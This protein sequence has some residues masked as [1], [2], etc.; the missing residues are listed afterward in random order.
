MKSWKTWKW[1]TACLYR[2]VILKVRVGYIRVNI[3]V[4]CSENA[5]L[6]KCMVSDKEKEWMLKECIVNTNVSHQYERSMVRSFGL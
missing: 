6:K 5:I 3:K 2:L 4:E 1:K